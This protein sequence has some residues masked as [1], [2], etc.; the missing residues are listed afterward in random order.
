MADPKPAGRSHVIGALFLALGATSGAL[1]AHALEDVLTPE[2]LNSWATASL[3]L[4]VMGA[5]LVGAHRQHASPNSRRAL[6][7]VAAG[8][9]LFSASIMAL[10]ILATLDVAP[11]L[12]RVL[13]PM[14]PVGGVLMIGGW[15]VWAWL[16]RQR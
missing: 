1:G 5:A 11:G 7:A 2:R 12:R 13:G 9:V 4:L 8:T 15:V 14:T 16:Q 6:Q 10:V 3:Y